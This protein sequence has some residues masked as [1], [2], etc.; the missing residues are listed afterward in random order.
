MTSLRAL[1]AFNMK[2]KRR[3]IG[4]SQAKL[5]AKINTSTHYIGMIETKKK[6]PSPEMLER[7]ASA[8]EIDAPQLF[9]MPGFQL[10]TMH[11]FQEQVLSD[12][13]KTFVSRMQNFGDGT[14]LA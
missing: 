7:I 13:E 10:E 11:K 3:I 2:E 4:L 6:F 14:L 5:A 8:L 9:S 12:M 1:L